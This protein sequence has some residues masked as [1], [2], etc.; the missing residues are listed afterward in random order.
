MH[1][2]TSFFSV[3]GGPLPRRKIDVHPKGR[4]TATG[5]IR[6][7]ARWFRPGLERRATAAQPRFHS[8]N[9][10]P[11]FTLPLVSYA[12]AL[13]E[14]SSGST[15]FAAALDEN[16]KLIGAA[17]PAR[18]GRIIQLYANGL[19]P[20]TNTPVSGDP[21]PASPFAFTT[22]AP[23]VTIGGVNAPV[24]FSGL[25][26]TIVGVY[27]LNVTVPNTGAGT[28]PV[29]ITIGGVAGKASSIAVQ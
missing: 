4:P 13:F 3:I 8:G 16:F 2:R 12:P 9:S 21:T 24:Q 17:N 20:V 23:T 18:Q 7:P 10:G 22:T 29:V 5:P 15:L 14:Y 19:G 6:P 25:S 11:L 1:A 28:K 27:Q 26:P